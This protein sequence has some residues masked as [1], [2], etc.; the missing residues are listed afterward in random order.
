[1]EINKIYNGDSIDVLKNFS[2][3]SVDCI[4][5]SPPY[6]ALRD[7]GVSNQLGL[8]PTFKE[9]IEKLCNI[10]DECKRVLKNTGTCFVNIG[11]TYH[12][13]T[14]WTNKDENPQ[15][16]S[17]GNNRDFKT[18]K[19]LNQGIQEKCLCQ[20]PSRFAIEMCDRG[21]IL[22]NEIIWHK[23]NCM[24]QSAKDRFTVDFEKVFFFTKSKNYNFET[25]L[26]KATY[27]DSRKDK[28][29]I[30]YNNRNT[31]CGVKV[32]DYRNKRC[33]W[34]VNTKKFKGA[35]FAT[36]PEKLIEPMLKAG[37]PKDGIV[38]DPFMGGG[39]TALVAIKHNKNYVGIEINNDYIDIANSRI[40]KLQLKLL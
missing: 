40:Q 36:F 4:I 25:I 27:T 37:C 14:K 31:K 5:T 29:R 7:Y 12:N 26:E 23:L 2:D 15:T 30:E 11:D 13:A 21:W 38:L 22:R 8:E 19:R 33:V 1:M 24:P 35:H 39:T 10:F 17:R 18:G 6:L 32:T 34:N 16:M 3:E 9:Y 28:G 20:I